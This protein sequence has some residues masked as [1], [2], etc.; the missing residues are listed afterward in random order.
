MQ[1]V[2]REFVKTWA[3]LGAEGVLSVA[4][5][6]G[7][8]IVRPVPNQSLEVCAVS[9]IEGAACLLIAGQVARHRRHEP[10]DRLRCQARA[11]LAGLPFSRLIDQTAERCRGP[12]R[13]LFEPSPVAGKQRDLA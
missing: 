5:N 9:G 1:A 13:L 11:L 6:V 3:I 10:A 2:R 7:S 12:I 8:N 4:L